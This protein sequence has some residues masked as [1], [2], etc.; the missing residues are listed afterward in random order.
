MSASLI[1]MIPLVLLGLVTALCFVGCVFQTGG[2]DLLGV[3]Q[4]TVANEA[5]LVACWPL[6]D[7]A[8]I[9]DNPDGATALDI[10]KNKLNGT[11]NGA[12]LSVKVMQGGIVL[13][14]VPVGTSTPNTCAF[15]N[16]G[17]VT[18]PFNQALNP[19]KFT[20]EA[21]VKPNWSAT[22]MAVR[23]VVISL[24]TQ[25]NAGYSLFVANNSWTAAVGTG[26]GQPSV[27][28]PVTFNNNAPVTSYL[29]MTFDGTQLTLFV[30]I[31]GGTLTN[32][33]SLTIPGT[34]L[35]ENSMSAATPLFIG[36]GRPD[37][38]DGMFPL[39]GFVQDVA[40]YSD[41]LSSTTIMDH[42]NKGKG[43]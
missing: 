2:L 43:G 25:L 40:V 30:G 18:V 7:K 27:S 41:V 36:I 32:T 26:A 24:N 4:D 29:A 37:L 31:A 22:D 10:S 11:Y 12:A 3:Y 1:V 14:D 38:Q 5:T 13:G 15:F 9:P 28:L 23:G 8:E 34:F 19:A 6:N 39:D 16:G 35:P 20:V 21:W 33:P 42:F 17:R